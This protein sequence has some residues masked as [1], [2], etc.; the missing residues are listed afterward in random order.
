MTDTVRQL[1]DRDIEEAIKKSRQEQGQIIGNTEI[2]SKILTYS[3]PTA[4][5]SGSVSKS[6][7][8]TVTSQ[9]A[10]AAANTSILPTDNFAEELVNEIV[11]L[12]FTRDKVLA[13]LRS[14]KGDKT[15]AVAALIAKSF[16]FQPVYIFIKYNQELMKLPGRQNNDNNY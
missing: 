16:K 9:A 13:E 3:F 12:G 11:K 14:S 7:T 2:K 5:T 1:E 8:S 4:T 10:A 15:Q 6:A